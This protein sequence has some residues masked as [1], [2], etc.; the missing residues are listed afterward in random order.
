MIKLSKPEKRIAE[1]G[2]IYL[3]RTPEQVEQDL[4]RIIEKTGQKDEEF[5]EYWR[6]LLSAKVPVCP[7]CGEPGGPIRRTVE[8]E[9]IGCDKCLNICGYDDQIDD[10]LTAPEAAKMWGL[11]ESTVKKACQQGRFYP[12]EARKTGKVWLVTRAGMERVYGKP[13]VNDPD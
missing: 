13:K 8:G 7:K 11:E 12:H 10:I 6:K 2:I 9:I 5:K 1:N 4:A 3:L